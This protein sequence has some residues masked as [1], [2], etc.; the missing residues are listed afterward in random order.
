M[1]HVREIDTNAQIKKK[2]S[3]MFSFQMLG[4]N[5]VVLMQAITCFQSNEV[6]TLQSA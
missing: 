4:V 1:C 2:L 6:C 5:L 3:R